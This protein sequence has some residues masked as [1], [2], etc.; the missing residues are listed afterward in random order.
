MA[1]HPKRPLLT[2][3]IIPVSVQNPLRFEIVLMLSLSK[4]ECFDE[5]FMPYMPR[6]FKFKY[7]FRFR[8]LGIIAIWHYGCRLCMY[9]NTFCYLRI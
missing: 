4:T 6:R 1:S 5:L 8:D 2:I 3:K 9:E 7:P